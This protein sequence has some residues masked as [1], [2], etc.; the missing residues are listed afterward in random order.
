M[1]EGRTD[2]D[3]GVGF[4][5]KMRR[6]RSL[7]GQDQRGWGV[8]LLPPILRTHL[9]TGLNRQKKMTV[10]ARQAGLLDGHAP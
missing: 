4:G 6:A 1:S 7:I 3:D 9:N 5:G 8:S 2:G 10:H